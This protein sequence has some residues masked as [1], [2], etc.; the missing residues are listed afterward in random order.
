MMNAPPVMP[1]TSEQRLYV[2]RVVRAAA[3][4]I[5]MLQIAACEGCRVAEISRVQGIAAERNPGG[6]CTTHKE[7]SG[8]NRCEHL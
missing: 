2:P 8:N 7:C 6:I 3:G 1:V 4:M 5:S